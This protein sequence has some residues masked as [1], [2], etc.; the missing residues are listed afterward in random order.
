MPVARLNG[1]LSCCRAVP[2]V[3]PTTAIFGAP[4]PSAVACGTSFSNLLTCIQEGLPTGATG[5]PETYDAT[6]DRC[7]SLVQPVAGA[8]EGQF[9]DS[10]VKPQLMPLNRVDTVYMFGGDVTTKFRVTWGE[11]SATNPGVTTVELLSSATAVQARVSS[12]HGGVAVCA[13]A[14]VVRRGTVHLRS[15]ATGIAR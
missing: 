11:P 8:C 9:F 1:L 15:E 10:V 13:R 6:M 2:C 12:H 14:D 4:V 5:V 7:C 3:L